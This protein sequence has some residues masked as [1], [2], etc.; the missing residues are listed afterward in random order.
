MGEDLHQRVYVKSKKTGNYVNAHDI[1]SWDCEYSLFKELVKGRNYDVF[2]LFGSRRSDYEELPYSNYG[3]PDFLKGS[4]F[5]DYCR[6]CGYY[7]FVWFKLPELKKA[8]AEYSERLKDPLRYLDP[9]SDEY[10]DWKDF[11]SERRSESHSAEFMEKYGEWLS[12]HRNVLDRLAEM[13]HDLEQYDGDRYETY[14]KLIDIDET[15]FLFFFDC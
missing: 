15:V 1:C 11:L 10:A 7:G 13:S 3:M 12:T 2:S 14:D 5:D 8:V 6:E 4:L 9:D